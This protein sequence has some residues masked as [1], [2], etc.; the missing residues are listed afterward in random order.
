M[1]QDKET[2]TLDQACAYARLV[3]RRV[4]APLR[5]CPDVESVAVL[6]VL[7]NWSRFDSKRSSWKHFVSICA[8]RSSMKEI[9]RRLKRQVSFDDSIVDYPDGHRT[10]DHSAITLLDLIHE[11]GFLST[12]ERMLARMLIMG[13]Q[14]REIAQCFSISK[15]SISVKVIALRAKLRAKMDGLG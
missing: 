13:Y 9:R 4:Q 15:Q 5:S 6:S 14:Q 8:G 10:L 3:A 11:P 1:S 12:R 7:T 2:V